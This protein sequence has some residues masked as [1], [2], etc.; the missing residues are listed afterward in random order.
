MC[1]HHRNRF[2]NKTRRNMAVIIKCTLGGGGHK[3]YWKRSIPT[4]QSMMSSANSKSPFL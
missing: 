3:D 1:R 2:I 4:T